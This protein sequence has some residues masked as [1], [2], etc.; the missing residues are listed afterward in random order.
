MRALTFALVRF[1][2]DAGLRERLAGGARPSAEELLTP[3]EEY[4]QRVAALVE[5]V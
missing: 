1:C 2:T 5:G 3:P 4:A